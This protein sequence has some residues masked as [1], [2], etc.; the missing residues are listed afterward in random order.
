MESQGG[1]IGGE[2]RTSMAGQECGNQLI[3]KARRMVERAEFKEVEDVV[4]QEEGT[5]VLNDKCRGYD[6]VTEDNDREIEC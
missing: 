5:V 2:G 3:R 1:Q 4:G 6:D